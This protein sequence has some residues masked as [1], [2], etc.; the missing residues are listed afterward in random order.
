M[1]RRL[2]SVIGFV[3]D[4]LQIALDLRDKIDRL[5]LLRAEPYEFE[6]HGE[7]EHAKWRV[8]NLVPCPSGK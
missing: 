7:G 4:A 3:E 8:L 6:R 2:T 5:A 1:P